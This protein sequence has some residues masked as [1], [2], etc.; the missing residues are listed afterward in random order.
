MQ[1]GHSAKL[2]P[3]LRIQDQ[4]RHSSDFVEFPGSHPAAWDGLFYFIVALPEPS[5]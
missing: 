3:A 5:I 1:G 4:Q 2:K